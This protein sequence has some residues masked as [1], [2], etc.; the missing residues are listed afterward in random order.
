MRPALCVTMSANLIDAG[1]IQRLDREK[2]LVRDAP[3]KLPEGDSPPPK[4]SSGSGF[5]DRFADAFM[6]A[7]MRRL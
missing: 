6:S 5:F 4:E 1:D 2:N 7:L 3:T